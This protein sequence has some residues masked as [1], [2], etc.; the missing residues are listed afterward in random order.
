M[1]SKNRYFAFRGLIRCGE[2][3]CT[4]TAEE[5]KGHNYY[6]CTKR[7]GECSQ[8]GYVREEKLALMI[9]EAIKRVHLDDRM[10]NPML[11]ELE[12]EKELLRAGKIH[13]E[14]VREVRLQEIDK[15]MS[16]LLDLYVEGAVSADEYKEKKASLIN[17]KTH[18]LENSSGTNGKWL[19]PMR[20]FLS[21]A[22]QA[23][24]IAS[25]GNYEEKRDFLKR[26][27]SNF[28]LTDATVFASYTYP[29]KILA[30]GRNLNLG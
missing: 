25:A 26:I 17:R 7:R 15:Q 24:Y 20:D 6:H 9:S 28:K 11:Q 13:D 12:R 18:H 21:L 27:G 5:Q 2:C 8:Q 10:Y 23:S 14:R 1:L 29:F 30:E 22:H 19:E 16:R 3:G 4:I